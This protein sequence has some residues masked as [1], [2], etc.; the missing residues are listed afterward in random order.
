[1]KPSDIALAALAAARLTRFISSDKLGDW[2][3][4]EPAKRWAT[5]REGGI[6]LGYGV[7]GTD[8]LATSEKVAQEHRET[9]ERAEP[10]PQRGW[11]SKLVSGL[12]CPF[13]LGFWIGTFTL[14]TAAIC[15]RSP[16]SRSAFRFVAGSLGMNYVLGH[17][18][19]RID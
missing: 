4:V 7:N 19:A 5:E 11:R 6:M 3:I 10:Y 12:E 13:C 8:I 15:N 14:G 16:R 18:Q 1:M 2:W 9:L 17:L